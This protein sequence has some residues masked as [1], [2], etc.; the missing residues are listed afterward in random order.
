MKLSREKIMREAERFLK[1]TEQY[2]QRKR[3]GED[4]NFQIE[5]VL[6]K[7]GR[8]QPEDIIA[9]AAY[10][11][12]VICFYPFRKE[13]TAVDD[14]AFDFDNDLFGYLEKGYEIM[15]MTLNSHFTVS[16][17]GSE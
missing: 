5:F 8:T 4:E 15:G 14:W 7:E 11:D 1:R 12:N 10:E 17:A 9:Y 13:K 6:A 3:S 16:A 2:Q